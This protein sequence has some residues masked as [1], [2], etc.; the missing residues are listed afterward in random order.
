MV[1]CA[2]PG[3]VL[4]DAVA[5]L[6]VQQLPAG[7][8][9][10]VEKPFGHDRASAWQ[11][12]ASL[13]RQLPGVSVYRVD[14][15]L[16][17][18]FARDLV[19]R[20]LADPGEWDHRTVSRVEVSWEE[21]IPVPA[22][23]ARFYDQTGA[24]R[25]M[26]QSHL[27][28]LLA[29]VAMDPPAAPEELA[30]AKARVLARVLAPT[31]DRLRHSSVRGRYTSGITDGQQVPAYAE[32]VGVDPS[33]CTETFTSVRLHLDDERWRGVPFDLSAGKA[34]GRAHKGVT[35]H[36]TGGLAPL[37]FAFDGPPDDTAWLPPSS[38]ILQDLLS[39]E[40]RWAVSADE[41]EECWRV[42]DAVHAGWAELGQ[43]LQDYPAGSSG[44]RSTRQG[45]L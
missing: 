9:L 24:V 44:P 39:D 21:T 18:Q 17:H 29:L 1:Y 23:R 35:V 28:Q 2:L 8:R 16:H 45:H 22:A 36:R 5:W 40:Q 6:A 42:A 37:R 30:V 4:P 34:L 26:L 38:L 43:P 15:V 11:L 41:V 3:P 32:L 7:T 19:A 31:P 14:H 10:A 20:R 25:D 33:R 27:L 13:E 12:S